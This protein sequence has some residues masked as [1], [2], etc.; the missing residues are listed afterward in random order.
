M[1]YTVERIIRMP[2][3]L[4]LLSL[5]PWGVMVFFFFASIAPGFQVD[6]QGR[7]VSR[8]Q[9]WTSGAGIMVTIG[10]V[11]FSAQFS[12]VIYRFKQCRVV[13]VGAWLF[14]ALTE[15]T[16]GPA[17]TQALTGSSS[18]SWML[19]SGATAFIGVIA[20]LVSTFTPD[21]RAFLG[22]QQVQQ[23]TDDSFNTK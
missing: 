2:A 7:I 5:A 16:V 13:M 19:I 23:R 22:L 15:L 8:I 3:P 4:V 14:F 18:D 20:Y 10:V 6:V 9:W 12:A 17:A 11:I 21:V 1:R